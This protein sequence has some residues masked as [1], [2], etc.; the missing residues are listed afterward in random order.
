MF[1]T[2]HAQGASAFWEIYPRL[3]CWFSS[4]CCRRCCFSNS[5]VSNMIGLLR[6][7]GSCFLANFCPFVLYCFMRYSLEYPISTSSFKRMIR[8]G[9]F[10][11]SS[12]G[13]KLTNP[14]ISFKR[15]ISS[16]VF[17]ITSF[18]FSTSMFTGILNPIFV[19][20]LLGFSSVKFTAYLP[21]TS[22]L[23]S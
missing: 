18:S 17:V 19:F 23:V 3:I 14:L 5:S 21:P 6:R 9:Y 13:S 7:V 4:S 15:P 16:F 20:L 22:S 11:V 8:F 1:L 10:G 12:V 2:H